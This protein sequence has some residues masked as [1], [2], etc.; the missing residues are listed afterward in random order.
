MAD[1][2]RNSAM[3]T[4]DRRKRSETSSV[5]AAAKD[6]TK[7]VIVLSSQEGNASGNHNL[8]GTLRMKGCIIGHHAFVPRM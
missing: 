3:G 6:S 2:I 7:N 4:R 8:N 1:H 5:Q